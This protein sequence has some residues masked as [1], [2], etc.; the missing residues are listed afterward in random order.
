MDIALSIP[1]PVI[2]V[3]GTILVLLALWL[4]ARLLYPGN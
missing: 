1:E 2:Y 3:G 4:S